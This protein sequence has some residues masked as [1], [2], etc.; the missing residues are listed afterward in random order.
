[1]IGC[2]EMWNDRG[3]YRMLFQ[4]AISIEIDLSF[5]SELQTPNLVIPLRF[6]WYRQGAALS[7]MVHIN[8]TEEDN[9]TPTQSV[10]GVIS[11]RFADVSGFV[12]NNN[13]G[14]MILRWRRPKRS[15]DVVE[16][17][18]ASLVTDYKTGRVLGVGFGERVGSVGQGSQKDPK[19]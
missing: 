10:I 9:W 13:S 12:K 14:Q 8:G 7:R 6:L 17:K 1:M 15:G 16:A 3:M 4:A 5:T 2:S 11:N 19:A 18:V